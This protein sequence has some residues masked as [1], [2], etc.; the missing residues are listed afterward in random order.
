M[1]CWR[2][3]L[4]H[5]R[6]KPD[7]SIVIP[8]KNAVGIIDGLIESILS[9]D[10]PYPFEIIF[11]LTES[12]DGTENYLKKIPF[13]CKKIVHIPESE[14]NHS[15]TRMKGAELA[16]GRFIIFFTED[17]LPQGKDFLVQLIRPVLEQNIP[18]VYGTYQTDPVRNDPVMAYL[19]N[20]WHQNF[21]EITLPA[22][23]SEW[24]NLTP[25]ERRKR[26]NF[27][28]CAS[29]I[30][31]EL[32]LKL[33]LP[34]VPYGEDMFFAK[35]LILNGHSIALSKKARFIHWHK[36]GFGY[37]LRRQCLDQHLSLHEFGVIYV[38]NKISLIWNIMTRLVHRAIISIF[39]LPLPFTRRFFWTGYHAKIIIA[40]FVGKYMGKL[41]EKENQKCLNPVNKWLYRL[42]IRILEDI[43]RRSIPRD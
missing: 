4:I 12:V 13:A 36:M 23:R 35:K 27:D 2:I 37:C 29:C 3:T 21:P 42:K 1:N 26:C 9:Q 32:I 43:A 38:K 18:A 31:K 14:F 39:F 16:E 6:M 11:L 5:E 24:E 34:D 20:N 15:S 7:F 41:T 8:T 30:K 22:N 17:I 40:E 33:R 10:F 28:N 25:L 19:N